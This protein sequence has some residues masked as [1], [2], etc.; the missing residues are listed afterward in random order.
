MSYNCPLCAYDPRVTVSSLA[1]LDLGSGPPESPLVLPKGRAMA[2][3]QMPRPGS[4]ISEPQERVRQDPHPPE[5]PAPLPTQCAF[6]SSVINNPTLALSIT[7]LDRR[8][9]FCIHWHAVLWS[10]HIRRDIMALA[11]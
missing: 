5:R 8:V 4:T 6:C 3:T 2:I 11:P 1:P 7:V 9:D 10:D